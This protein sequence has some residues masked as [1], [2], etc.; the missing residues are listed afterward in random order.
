[1]KSC[2]I[3]NKLKEILKML[4]IIM[5]LSAINEIINIKKQNFEKRLAKLNEF[6][7]VALNKHIKISKELAK[8]L[9]LQR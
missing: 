5:L 8:K 6:R 4:F 7:K 3:N 1:M 2:I 9:H